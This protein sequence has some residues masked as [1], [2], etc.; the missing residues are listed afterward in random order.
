LSVECHCRRAKVKELVTSAFGRWPCKGVDMDF[1]HIQQDS[2]RRNWPGGRRQYAH[3]MRGE[4]NK[5]RFTTLI[6]CSCRPGRMFASGSNRFDSVPLEYPA[7]GSIADAG[8]RHNNWLKSQSM[9]LAMILLARTVRQAVLQEEKPCISC[10]AL[11]WRSTC[12]WHFFVMI[13]AHCRC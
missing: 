12:R 9:L 13:T 1:Q 8:L 10:S 4:L 3:T 11:L 6:S 5:D 7:L 2:S